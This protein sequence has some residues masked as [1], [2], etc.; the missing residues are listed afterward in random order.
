MPD[1]MQRKCGACP[2]I[3]EIDKNNVSNVVYYQKRYYHLECFC[4]A[5]AKRSQHKTKA[6]SEWKRAL[7]NLQEIEA[8][9]KRMIEAPPVPP[10]RTDE[11]NDWILAHY[12]VIS[13]PGYFWNL[14]YDLE[15]GIFHKK[16]CKPISIEVLT[17][18][19][20]WGQ[21]KL[22][23]ISV[24]N[25]AN[26]KGPK[27]DAERINYDLS[28]VV[29]HVADYIKYMKKIKSAEIEREN[30]RKEEIKVDYN[31]IKTSS[32][33]SYGLDDISELLDDLI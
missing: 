15:K 20:K 10:R 18:T 16:K 5:A 9:T 30:K 6:A 14:V 26:N 2:N 27:N 11:L 32:N 22:D 28:I 8:D 7:D 29:G 23:E 1:I 31:K 33:D 13:L 4:K 12:D 21:R 25:K 19:W 17:A 24:R 3:I